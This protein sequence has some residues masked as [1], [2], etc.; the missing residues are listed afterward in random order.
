MLTCACC[1]RQLHWLH[2]I[3]SAAPYCSCKCARMHRAQLRAA[4]LQRGGDSCPEDPAEGNP[5]PEEAAASP[6]RMIT[7]G[8]DPEMIPSYGGGLSEAAGCEAV[9]GAEDASCDT[10]PEPIAGGPSSDDG[11]P[12]G[13]EDA[14]EQVL[15]SVLPGM[16]PPAAPPVRSFAFLYARTA[17]LRP[18]RRVIVPAHRVPAPQPAL[19]PA[20][21]VAAPGWHRPA[22]DGNRNLPQAFENSR[23]NAESRPGVR[24]FSSGAGEDGPLSVL[25]FSFESGAQQGPEA[26]EAG[27]GPGVRA[28]AASSR[29]LR[30]VLEPLFGTDL[31]PCIPVLPGHELRWQPRSPVLP[32]PVPGA[33]LG[34]LPSLR[35]LPEP[36]DAG[37]EEQCAVIQPFRLH[38]M[39]LRRLAI[40]P[41]RGGKAT[42]I[43]APAALPSHAFAPPLLAPKVA[44]TPLRPGYRLTDPAAAT[45]PGAV[46]GPPSASSPGHSPGG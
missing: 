10:F 13:H 4:A 21:P 35:L 27:I 20:G 7:A 9:P 43:A 36:I 23:T 25:V 14:R 30:P 44:L 3:L 15:D 18:R 19:A 1:G 38:R 28:A 2:R 40:P 6:A 8:P 17:A 46:C 26:G 29:L 24:D 31:A 34:P 22:G 5:A 39:P 42:R 45:G 12:P 32:H 41:H 16:I 33:G 11:G 37:L